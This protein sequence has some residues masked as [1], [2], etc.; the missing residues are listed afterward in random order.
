LKVASETFSCQLFDAQTGEFADFGARTEASMKD[1][2]ELHRRVKREKRWTFG[3]V[4]VGVATIHA[5]Q[6][7]GMIPAIKSLSKPATGGYGIIGLIF[8]N[9]FVFGVSVICAMR[10]MGQ[11]ESEAESVEERESLEE[12]ILVPAFQGQGSPLSLVSR[13]LHIPIA[14]L[15]G[16]IAGSVLAWVFALMFF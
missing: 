15:V 1:C 9:A 3:I 11:L 5:L 6:D 4:V 2:A 7:S 8:L 14:G 12:A 10:Q 16:M 13:Y